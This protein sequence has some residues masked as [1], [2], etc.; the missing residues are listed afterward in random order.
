MKDTFL[1][2]DALL[3][4]H[5]AQHGLHYASSTGVA[6]FLWK[7]L[8]TIAHVGDSKACIARQVGEQIHPEWLT[9]D[10]KPNMPHELARI[11]SNG[12]SLAW[13]HGNKPY[14]RGG[15]FHR[16]QQNGE[17]PKQ[18]NYSRAFGGKD[19]KC[20]GL[21]AEPDV[22]H[23]QLD[24]DDKLL[25]LASDGLWDVLNPKVA[26]ELALEA[27]KTGR[28]ASKELVDWAI[29]EMP[30]CN[31]RDNVTVIAIFLNE[32]RIDEISASSTSSD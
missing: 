9:I 24:G 28:N 25:I 12:G 4:N 7:N 6:G 2:T 23:F 20:Y 11:E 30:G 15:D 19:L 31:V 14:I 5:C 27:R 29:Q 8:L 17:H 3:L 16:R 26:C 18:L 1:T 32:K 13:L 22:S 10:H 21:S